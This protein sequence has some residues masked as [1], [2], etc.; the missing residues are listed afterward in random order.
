MKLQ[1]LN[2]ENVALKKSEMIA[3]KGGTSTTLFTQVGMCEN[4]YE[5][6]NGNGQLDTEEAKAKPILMGC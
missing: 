4:E 2:K 5:D 6:T 3:I 1:K